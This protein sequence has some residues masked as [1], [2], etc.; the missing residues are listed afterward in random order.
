M[1][2]LL[3]RMATARGG[4]EKTLRTRCGMLSGVVGIILNVI[5]FAAKYF[6][7][8]ISGSI[9][10]TADAFNNLSDAASCSVNVF[11]FKLSSRPADK[12]HPFGHG[13][14]EYICAMVVTFLVLIM[15]YELASASVSKIFHPESVTF[16]VVSAA[17]LVVSIL[18]KLW[19]ALFNRTL[20][21][22]IHSPALEATAADSFGDMAATGATL[23]SLILSKFTALPLDGWFGLGVAVF[24]FIAGIRLFRESSDPLL[25]QPPEKEFVDALVQKVLSYDGIVGIHDLMIHDYGPGQLFGSIH[26]EVPAS[27]DIMEAHDTIDLIE[28]DVQRE[29]GMLLSIH[30]DPI[31]TDDEHVSALRE[32]TTE[33]IRAIDPELT[34]HDFRMVE[35]PSHTNLIFDLV[36][37]HRYAVSDT[38][39]TELV[40]ERLRTALGENVFAVIHVEQNFV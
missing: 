38:E 29:M 4:D 5:L 14:L 27:C 40:G 16:S 32:A 37:P 31:V 8:T 10:I 20:G 13:R 21:K 11:G 36:T 6:A 26:A 9:A 35:G 23:L 1:I 28:Q 39:L 25:G 33:I 22:K 24:I 30:M 19:L 7:G 2:R 34:M 15:G 18:G 12:E 3:I 17:I